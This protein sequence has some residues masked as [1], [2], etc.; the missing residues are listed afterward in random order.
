V[1]QPERTDQIDQRIGAAELVKVDLWLGEIVEPRL[2]A[3]ETLECTER[4]TLDFIGEFGTAFAFSAIAA[5]LFLGG[6]SIPGIYD[7]GLMRVLGPIVLFTKIMAVA[8]LMFWVRFT[9]PR[10]REDQL[11]ALAWKFLI[12][13]GLLNILATG[14]F[15]V[16]F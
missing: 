1:E 11:Q 3:T 5:T 15:K 12:P 2:G 9:Y 13:I 14:V 16:A 6:W 7:V 8:F 10:L 4:G